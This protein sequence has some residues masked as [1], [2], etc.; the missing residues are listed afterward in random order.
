MA[1]GGDLDP[2][3]AY[4]ESFVVSVGALPVAVLAHLDVAA[5]GSREDPDPEKI[6]QGL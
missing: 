2:S 3:D 5:A 4:V 6:G 1:T